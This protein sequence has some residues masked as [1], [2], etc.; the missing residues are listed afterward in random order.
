MAMFEQCFR[1]AI[2][3]RLLLLHKNHPSRFPSFLACVRK[4]FPALARRAFWHPRTM[5]KM[6]VVWCGRAFTGA[7]KAP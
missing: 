3:W 7:G 1:N 4:E 2:R 6:F 5:R